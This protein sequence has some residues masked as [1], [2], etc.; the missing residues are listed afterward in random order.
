MEG[1]PVSSTRL[2]LGILGDSQCTSETHEKID[3]VILHTEDNANF[4]QYHNEEYLS[5]S[6]KVRLSNSCLNR[7]NLP[8]Y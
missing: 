7:F 2:K 3:I 1:L 4:K 5:Y 8:K 6:F